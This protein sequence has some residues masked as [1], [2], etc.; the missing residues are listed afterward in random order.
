MA[1]EFLFALFESGLEAH[2]KIAALLFQACFR[3][4]RLELELTLHFSAQLAFL[5][6]CGRAK[7]GK[8]GV[9]LCAQLAFMLLK[10]GVRGQ[11]LLLKFLSPLLIQRSLTRLQF[12]L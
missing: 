5:L 9:H 11:L 7:F 12:P 2:F 6:L 1:G 10:L 8:A 4:T 3:L